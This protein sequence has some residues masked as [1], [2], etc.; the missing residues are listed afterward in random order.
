LFARFWVRPALVATASA[1]ML[2]TRDPQE[3]AA[4]T[5]TA[6][7]EVEFE[8]PEHWEDLLV[9]DADHARFVYV[10][11]RR[12]LAVEG[13]TLPGSDEFQAA[14]GAL[15]A[16]GYTLQVALRSRG[17]TT[18][19]GML[20]G[21]YW[22]DRP[23]PIPLERFALEGSVVPMRWRLLLVTPEEATDDEVRAA[24]VEAGKR[25]TA[26]AGAL[27]HLTCKGWLEGESAQILHVGPY[28]AEYPTASRLH[29]AMAMAGLRAR[30]CHHEIYLS[31][32]S[33]APERTRTIIRQPVE[34]IAW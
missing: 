6:L 18:T 5:V 17:V 23:E 21:V 13:D 32:P 12:Y 16:V 14:I 10:P 28:D 26:P 34:E 25:G 2:A 31:A 24:I 7:P 27:E 22:M 30:G 3:K 20:E 9:A 33:E 1:A 8:H 4:M 11:Y 15:Y 19:V 29:D